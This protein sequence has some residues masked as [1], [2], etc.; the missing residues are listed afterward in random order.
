IRKITMNEVGSPFGILESNN[1]INGDINNI[2]YTLKLKKP[3]LILS[4]VFV[5][6]L[7]LYSVILDFLKKLS[8]INFRNKYAYILIIFLCFLI[9][10]NIIYKVFYDKFDHKNYENRVLSVKPILDVKY[11]DKY[12]KE[13]ETY[14]ND[15]ILF[16]NELLKLKNLIDINSIYITIPKYFTV[17]FYSKLISINIIFR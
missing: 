2:V 8:K 7:L 4:S 15:Y 14:F 1:K 5:I 17:I 11:L 12:P 6:I 13:Y 9:M 10:P 16:K 3:I